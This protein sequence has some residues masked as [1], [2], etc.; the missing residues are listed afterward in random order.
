MFDI[1]GDNAD[2]LNA[3]IVEDD[4]TGS[5]W[6]AVCVQTMWI[7]RIDIEQGDGLEI[8]LDSAVMETSILLSTD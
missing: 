7:R 8:D 3:S 5:V 1:D 6:W 2:P 4:T